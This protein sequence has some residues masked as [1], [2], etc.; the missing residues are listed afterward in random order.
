MSV[1]PTAGHLASWAGQRSGNDQSAGERRSGRTREASK[2][3][4]DALKDAA[5][6]AIRTNDSYTRAAVSP[7]SPGLLH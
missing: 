2:W 5:M 4:D 6:G 7:A 3:L 1:F